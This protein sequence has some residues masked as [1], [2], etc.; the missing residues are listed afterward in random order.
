MPSNSL[1]SQFQNAGYLFSIFLNRDLVK[2]SFDLNMYDFLNGEHWEKHSIKVKA[3]HMHQYLQLLA[4]ATFNP[5]G[6]MEQQLFLLSQSY[7]TPTLRE[8]NLVRSH[9]CS[10]SELLARFRCLLLSFG[11]Y[12]TELTAAKDK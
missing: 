1:Y 3:L 2:W 4:N 9:S 12:S 6:F 5:A 10:W 8:N 11:C 7:L